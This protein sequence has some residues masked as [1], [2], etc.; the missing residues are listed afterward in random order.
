MSETFYGTYV[1]AGA[2]SG[3]LGMVD[4]CSVVFYFDGIV[5]TYL[6]AFAAGNTAV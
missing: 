4:G 3:T 2:A 6:R 5:G 1:D